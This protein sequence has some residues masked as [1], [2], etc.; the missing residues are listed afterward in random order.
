MLTQQDLKV[1]LGQ[2]CEFAILLYQNE[3]TFIVLTVCN[4][5]I[6]N[7]NHQNEHKTKINE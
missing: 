6:I 1:L 3:D 5:V 2:L 7:V 4:T